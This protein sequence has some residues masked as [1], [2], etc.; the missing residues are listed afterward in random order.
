MR[1]ITLVLIALL[2]L[3]AEADITITNYFSNPSAGHADANRVAKFTVDGSQTDFHD[4]HILQWPVGTNNYYRYSEQYG[5]GSVLN[6][7]GSWC[8][9]HVW[10]STDLGADGGPGWKDLGLLFDPSSYQTRC[11]PAVAGAPSGCWTFR[12]VRNA[13]NSN[14]VA[15]MHDPSGTAQPAVFVCTP[16]GSGPPVP[17]NA[18]CV[19]QSR[20]T[21]GASCAA[22][23]DTVYLFVDD[24][25]SA[26]NVYTCSGGT[27]TL[28][29]DKLNS[30]YTNWDGVNTT[31]PA[32][33]NHKEGQTLFRKG[34]TYY[35]VYED[36]CAYCDGHEVDYATASSPLGTYTVQGAIAADG[37]NGQHE[38]LSKITISGTDYYLWHSDNWVLQSGPFNNQGMAG[39]IIIPLSFSGTAISTISCATSTITNGGI[40]AASPAQSYPA[41]VSDETSNFA[42]FCNINATT[43][44]MQTFIAPATANRIYAR[45]TTAQ[46]LQDCNSL[47]GG[48]SAIDGNLVV[49]LVTLDG[50][51][52]PLAVLGSAVIASSNIVWR[53]VPQ[54][55]TLNGPVTNGVEYGLKLRGTNTV[56]CYAFAYN[57]NLPYASGVARQSTNGGSTWSTVSNRS[58]RFGVSAAPN[59]PLSEAPH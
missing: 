56:G 47:S 29:I 38:G 33:L 51:K 44:E 20:P 32:G 24:D 58:Y 30:T 12:I 7:F 37:C 36:L 50:S 21:V 1:W 23:V 16:S 40:T 10:Y 41:D 42:L 43:Q 19:E 52:N 57:E 25:G 48:C 28:N 9:I 2:P 59:A 46:N 49:E 15:W 3:R 54:T 34:S 8:G 17:G 35:L 39:E 4:S 53:M 55:V 27:V 18:G 22:G 13:A 45:L 6:N 31:S 11:G 5:C 14:F 26:Y